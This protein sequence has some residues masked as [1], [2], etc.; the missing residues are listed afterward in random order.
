MFELAGTDRK[1]LLADVLGLLSGNGC[2]I[3][4][5]AVWTH[6]TR[7]RVRERVRARVRQE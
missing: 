2:S 1:G 3:R 6:H 5:L 4:T 7:V